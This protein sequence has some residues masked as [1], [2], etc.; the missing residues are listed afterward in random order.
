MVA[1]RITWQGR[2]GLFGL[3]RCDGKAI[4]KALE[5][6]FCSLATFSLPG[7]RGVP[8]IKL[9]YGNFDVRSEIYSF[10]VDDRR[11]VQHQKKRGQKEFSCSSMNKERLLFSEQLHNSPVDEGRRSRG[12]IMSIS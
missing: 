7:L 3:I 9:R 5:T 2:E 11:I 4:S 6:S 12:V 8:L 10:V 1:E